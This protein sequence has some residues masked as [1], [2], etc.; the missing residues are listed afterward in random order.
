MSEKKQP[1]K[2]VEMT[3]AEKQAVIEGLA[4]GLG[5]LRQGLGA[6]KGD[7]KRL[8][9]ADAQLAGAAGSLNEWLKDQ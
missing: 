4:H 1:E 9:F 5:N 6:F 2:Q 7:D 8:L 3:A